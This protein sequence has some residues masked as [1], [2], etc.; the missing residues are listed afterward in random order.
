MAEHGD[1]RIGISGWRY[2]GWRGIFYPEKL[3][4]RSELAFCGQKFRAVEIN[5]TFYSLQRPEYFAAWAAAL[6]APPAPAADPPPAA[7]F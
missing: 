6:T 5:G 1:I 2:R 7:H 4:Q 3:P